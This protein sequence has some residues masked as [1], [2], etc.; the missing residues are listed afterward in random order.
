MSGMSTVALHR[1]FARPPR[2]QIKANPAGYTLDQRKIVLL[3]ELGRN[4]FMTTEQLAAADGGSYQKVQ[5]ILRILFDHG[6]IHR[7]KR[8]QLDAGEN[9]SLIHTLTHAGAR[10]LADIDRAPLR[11][12]NWTT[13][14]KR[15][16]AQHIAHAVDIAQVM[17]AF[18]TSIRT[19][20]W[21]L[22]DHRELL[23][24]FPQN[25]RVGAKGTSPFS[26]RLKIV[27]DGD[28]EPRRISVIP[29]RLFSPCPPGQRLN[30]ALELDEGSMPVFRW[31][32]RKKQLIN[33]DDTSIV[34]K[35]LVYHSAWKQD[36][37][38]ERWA[39]Q[40]FRV[41]F[42]TTTRERISEMLNAVDFVT[43]GKGSRL[44]AFTDRATLL[45]NDPLEAIWINGKRETTALLD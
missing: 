9:S 35:L 24:Y 15:R 6:L 5:R 21:G 29:D 38:A 19:R 31:K 3:R 14:S 17:Q 41:L 37:H 45:A 32:N 13:K 43:N 26:L 44:F 40:K 25:S 30:F 8:F 12:Y 4:K 42:V 10:M 2:F 1:P 20:S 33:L 39:F 16:K 28:D 34:R 23:P 36:L 11:D 7:A 22:L 18:G 27:Q